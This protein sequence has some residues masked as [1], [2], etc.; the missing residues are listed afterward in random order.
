MKIGLIGA[1]DPKDK[2]ASSGTIY[3]MVKALESLNFT[4]VWVPVKETI[5]Y[6]LY[7]KIIRLCNKLIGKSIMVSHTPIGAYLLSKSISSQKIDDCDIL[8]AP[9]SSSSLYALKTNKKIVYLS[10]ATFRVMVDYYFNPM[11]SFSVRYGDKVE[12]RA[13]EK[14]AVAV[15]SSDWA[16]NSA[17]ND[18]KQPQE[19]IKVVEFGANISDDVLTY[20]RQNYNDYENGLN[21]LF[22]GVDWE[23]KG[24][25]IAIEAVKWLNENHVKAT[26]YIVGIKNLRDDYAS[27]SYVVNCGFLNKNNKEEYE[28]LVNLMKNMHCLLLPTV[29]ECSAIAFCEACAYGMPVFTHDTGGVKN[30]I[31]NSYNGYTLPLGS[32]GEDFG[33]VIK[34][35]LKSGLFPTMSENCRN[36]YE[37]TLNWSKWA[38]K[39]KSIIDEL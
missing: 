15:F 38:L 1:F 27:L 3:S 29:A 11:P 22:S 28:R 34:T 30:Y 24:G 7:E 17:I 33:K 19:K 4:I 37:N 20:E 32:T 13:M 9:F 26:L 36:V 12:R 35:S 31:T 6:W 5:L 21:I 8:F 25:D 39:M 23:R 16:K 2:R 10:D 18:Y 14:S